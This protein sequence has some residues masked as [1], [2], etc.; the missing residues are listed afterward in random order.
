MKKKKEILKKI[1]ELEPI[2]LSKRF[3]L[4]NIFPK[5]LIL[6]IFLILIV[7]FV[8][9]LLFI[10][11][12]FY[13]LETHDK[14]ND[15]RFIIANSP[16]HFNYGDEAILQSTKEFLKFYFPFNEQIII[17]NDEILKNLRLIKYII[18]KNDIII[19]NG[20]GYYGL[21]EFYIK[22]QTDIV[23]AFPNNHIIFF[24]C[25]IFDNTNKK[26]LY[27]RF[28]QKFNNHP[29]LTLFTRDN[30]SYQTSLHLF[31]TKDIFKVPD[32]VSRLNISFL[33]KKE[34]RDGIL[35]ILRKDEL[36]LKDKDI[37]YIKYLAEKYFKNHIFE[38][39]SNNF[40][41]PKGSNELKETYN[42]ISQLAQKQ[43]VITDRLHGFIFSIIT[44]T[45]CIVFGNNYHKVKSSYESWFQNYDYTVFINHNDIEKELEK[46]IIKLKN[47]TKRVNYDYNNFSQYYLLMKNIIQKKINS[48]N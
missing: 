5:L 26:K 8:I 39:D 45:P 35:L 14:K 13:H 21:Y 28:L 11:K 36:L 23:E 17:S 20:G 2:L 34:K 31:K 7:L 10:I 19:I 27:S 9:L 24:P 3:S 18:K 46:T 1:D 47:Y 25:S 29:N 32:I 12:I 37:V 16:S 41:V 22:A 48:I 6:L 15:I 44:G 40:R 42:F 4:L 38:K 30:V 33:E 43:L